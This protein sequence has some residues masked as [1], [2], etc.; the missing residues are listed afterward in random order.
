MS[1][2]SPRPRGGRKDSMSR[3]CDDIS[4]FLRDLRTV[5]R[6]AFEDLVESVRAAEVDGDSATLSTTE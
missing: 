2:H 6:D 3:G 1:R 4:M 5:I